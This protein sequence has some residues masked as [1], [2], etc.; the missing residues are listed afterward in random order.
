M[1]LRIASKPSQS[2]W[3]DAR[4]GMTNSRAFRLLAV[5]LC[6]LM[7]LPALPQNPSGAGSQPVGSITTVLAN[8]SVN[9]SP[10][11]AKQDLMPGDTIRTD[12]NGRVRLALRDGSVLSLG[13]DTELKIIR[14]DASTQVTILELNSGRLRSRV[15]P[16]KA[17][18]KFDID[19]PGAVAHVMGTDFFVSTQ[20][21]GNMQTIVYSGRVWLAGKG[22]Y[23]GK[24]ATVDANQMVELGQTGFTA[25]AMTPPS[26][27]LDS[28]ASTSTEGGSASGS[29]AAGANS[30]LLRNVLI[31][32]GVAATGIAIAVGRGAANRSGATPTST[33]TTKP[34][35]TSTGSAQ[36]A[37]QKH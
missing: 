36:P 17:G 25:V 5:F 15:V 9:A 22:D 3:P 26:V 2:S 14:H 21:S 19:M 12:H 10:A 28:S 16:V 7:A 6:V 18:G 1:L 4:N 11:K 32:V 29:A 37:P 34:A 13:P 20:P 33:S 23:A 35:T 24:S 27:Q 31:G 30:N 8:A